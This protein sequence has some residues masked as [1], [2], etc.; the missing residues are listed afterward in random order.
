MIYLSYIYLLLEN[1]L[2]NKDISSYLEFIKK[3][4]ANLDYNLNDNELN[5]IVNKQKEEEEARKAKEEATIKA[6]E[7]EKKAKEEK[8]KQKKKKKQE[9]Q[10]KKKKE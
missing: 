3:K 7:E 5:A 6:K 2:K 8:K 4:Y 1:K 9:K 10:K